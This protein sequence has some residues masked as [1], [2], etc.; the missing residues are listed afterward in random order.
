MLRIIELPFQR[1]FKSVEHS[2]AFFIACPQCLEELLCDVAFAESNKKVMNGFQSL[3]AG[4]IHTLDFIFDVAIAVLFGKIRG[5]TIGRPPK[6][7]TQLVAFL[8]RPDSGEVA[9]FDV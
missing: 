3:A 4:T 2:H 7:R 6:L 1:P 5:R 8:G 9:D